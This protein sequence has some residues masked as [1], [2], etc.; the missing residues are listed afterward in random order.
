MFQCRS[1]PG[2]WMRPQGLSETTVAPLLIGH[3]IFRHSTY[4]AWH[5]LRIPR[6]STVMDLSR[7]LGWAPPERYRTAPRAKPAALSAWHTP[8]YLAALADAEASGEVS[9]SVL[10]MHGLGTPSNPVF[11]EMYR[12]PATAAGGT[13]LAAE[14]LMAPDGPRRVHNPAGGTH[15]GMPDRAAGFCYLNDPVLGILRLLDLG[16]GRIAYVDLDA[17]HPDGVVHAFA[18]RPEV[19]VISTHEENRWPRTGALDDVGSGNVFNLPLPRGATDA[20]ARAA[21]DDLILPRVQAHHP[22]VVVLQCGADSVREDPLSGLDW[23]NR[24]Y[25]RALRAI[26]P[27]APRLLVLGGGGYNPYAT[28][29]LWTAL[30][31]TVSGQAIP[32]CLPTAAE[33]VLRGIE[34]SGTRLAREKPECWF[35]T[36]LDAPREGTVQAEVRSRLSI[37][38]ARRSP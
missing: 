25:V 10:R 1:P 38:R 8:R 36:L 11:P 26:I 2:A 23:T 16:A 9:P 21:L 34:W 29:R 20:D 5:P 35:T 27:L 17:H 33:S 13:L 32:E 14:L 15:H 30:W 22:D 24:A 7:A 3:E 6:V 18:A 31:A 28:G 37:L 19:L 4:G 12:R